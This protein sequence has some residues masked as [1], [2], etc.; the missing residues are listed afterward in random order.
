MP[1]IATGQVNNDNMLQSI[2]NANDHLADSLV[3][4]INKQAVQVSGVKPRPQLVP[5]RE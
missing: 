2:R 4:S 3:S 1:V 5:V